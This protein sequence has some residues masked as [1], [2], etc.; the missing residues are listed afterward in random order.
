MVAVSPDAALPAAGVATG[1]A[2]CGPVAAAAA[3]V[4]DV[5]PAAAAVGVAS[6]AAVTGSV[7]AVAASVVTDKAPDGSLPERA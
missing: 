1:W 5:A 7:L 4:C 3:V 2:T 6:A